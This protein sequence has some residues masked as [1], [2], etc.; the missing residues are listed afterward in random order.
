MQVL[1]QRLQLYSNLSSPLTLAVATWLP[2]FLPG[3]PEKS[4]RR[5]RQWWDNSLLLQSLLPLVHRAKKPVYMHTRAHSWMSFDGPSNGQ[6]G[7]YQFIWQTFTD[8]FQEPELIPSQWNTHTQPIHNTHIHAG[9]STH[10]G[11][12][13]RIRGPHST[14]VLSSLSDTSSPQQEPGPQQQRRSSAPSQMWQNSPSPTQT[15][16]G[17]A[18]FGLVSLAQGWGYCVPHWQLPPPPLKGGYAV[19][20]N[21]IRL[22][23]LQF[24]SVLG[25]PPSSHLL[26]YVLNV[27]NI[28]LRITTI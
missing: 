1:L 26:V 28:C 15:N 5:P 17:T 23:Y 21:T 6:P 24:F 22:I 11:P 14:L 8:A 19:L 25:F 10:T 4:Y 9:S 2:S 13:L 7:I 20:G 18:T 3:S 16:T 27:Q 12:C